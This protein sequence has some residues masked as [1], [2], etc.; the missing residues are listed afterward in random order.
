MEI[1]IHKAETKES[2]PVDLFI[3]QQNLNKVMD[4]LKH[5]GLL[6]NINQS[7]NLL[8]IIG[9]SS[10]ISPMQSVMSHQPIIQFHN[11]NLIK[12]TNNNIITDR[13]IYTEETKLSSETLIEDKT[14]LLKHKRANERI[15]KRKSLAIYQS[16]NSE[17]ES[18]SSNSCNESLKKNLTKG[19]HKVKVKSNT[20]KKLFF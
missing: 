20:N 3:L 7:N 5:L 14:K 13:G 12:T 10:N 9:S 8:P 6:Q 17:I 11:N 16:D 18:D 1:N 15:L 4:N 19:N 2:E